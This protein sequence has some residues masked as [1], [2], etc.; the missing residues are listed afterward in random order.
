MPHHFFFLG[1]HHCIVHDIIYCLLCS[2]GSAP[3]NM[4]VSLTDTQKGP[5]GILTRGCFT[6][7]PSIP[8]SSPSAEWQAC[9][10][11]NDIPSLFSTVELSPITPGNWMPPAVARWCFSCSLQPSGLRDSLVN[12]NIRTDT[13]LPTGFLYFLYF[14][15]LF[16]SLG[17]DIEYCGNTCRKTFFSSSDFCSSGP[18]GI[19]ICPILPIIGR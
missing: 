13:C 10:V 5:A 1:T 17:C 15:G 19:P 8:H 14:L 9:L 4:T 11:V 18:P 7:A 12:L 2:G 6:C 3:W 16:H